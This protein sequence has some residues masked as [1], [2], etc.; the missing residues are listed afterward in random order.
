MDFTTLTYSVDDRIATIT[1]NRPERLNAID[2]ATPREIRLAVEAA[3][4]DER[5][6]VIVL[7]GAGK[8]FCA[9]YDLKQYAEQDQVN[10]YTQPMPWDPMRDFALM[11][12]NTEDFMALWRSYKPTIARVHGYAAAGGSDIALCCDFI[13]MAEDAQIGYMPARVWGC[14]TTAMWVY[15]IGAQRAKQMLLTGDLI[16]G[17]T[18]KE[19]GLAVDA[20]PARRLEQDR[21]G[22]RAAHGRRAQEPADDA[23][24][25]HQPA[26]T[27]TWGSRARRC[28]RRCSTALRA[29]LPRGCGS[30]VMR[31]NSDSPRRPAGATVDARFRSPHPG[32]TSARC[33]STR[34]GNDVRAGRARRSA[35]NARIVSTPASEAARAHGVARG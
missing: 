16:D 30:S 14:P 15:R 9:G 13:V 27:S 12:R 29:T 26:Y 34:R 17:K 8:A 23:K 33:N 3:N 1:F 21:A 32:R 35:A 11:K 25:R 19:W 2:D 28:S 6:H 5:V 18:A 31:R 7:A 20:V 10:V 4:L 24:A 22:A